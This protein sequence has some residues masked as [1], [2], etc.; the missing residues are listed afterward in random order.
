MPLTD[1][2]ADM[3]SEKNA[4]TISIGVLGALAVLLTGKVIEVPVW[5]VFIAWA[6]F[7]IMGGG[8]T[9]LIRSVLS[10]LTGIAIASVCILLA[11]RAGAGLLLVAVIVGAGSALMVVASRLPLVSVVP[12]IVL[13][14]AS[15][16]GTVAV[17]GREITY[18]ATIGNPFLMV[19]VAMLLGAAFGF[20]SELF[21]AAMTKS[22]RRPAPVTS[23]G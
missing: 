3:M 13:G 1:S 7:F 9:G 17:T 8:T 20:V 15:T 12:T 6:S 18:T 21:A 11:E 19:V 22:I 5:V 14:F 23:K 2:K 10:N 4:L 16:V